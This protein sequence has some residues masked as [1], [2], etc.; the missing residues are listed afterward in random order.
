MVENKDYFIEKWQERLGDDNILRRY[1]A[2]QFIGIITEAEVV[3]EFDVGL[4]LALVEKMEVFDEGMVV[5]SLL[6]ETDLECTIE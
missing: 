2:K 4:Y 1:K 5:V 6:G 3:V